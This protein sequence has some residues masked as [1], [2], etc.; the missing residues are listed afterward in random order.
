MWNAYIVLTLLLFVLS[1]QHF[2]THFKFNFLLCIIQNWRWHKNC[3]NMFLKKVHQVLLV[4]ESMQRL[5][6][7]PHCPYYSLFTKSTK[8][9]KCCF[10]YFVQFVTYLLLQT[11][12]FFR[13]YFQFLNLKQDSRTTEKKRDI[14][15]SR[16][17][18]GIRHVNAKIMPSFPN[19]NMS[20]CNTEN[21]D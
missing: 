12:S 19:G 2:V 15:G 16:S 17:N 14:L 18:N 6:T 21:W 20:Y 10:V 1:N 5:G 13:C 8:N 3:R 11:F 9:S 4:W 7:Q